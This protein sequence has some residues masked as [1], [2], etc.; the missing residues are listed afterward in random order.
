MV[1]GEIYHRPNT[2]E[3]GFIDNYDKLI[4]SLGNTI[5]II[6]GDFNRLFKIKHK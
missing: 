6:G 5:C 4:S 3:S 2:S 1:I